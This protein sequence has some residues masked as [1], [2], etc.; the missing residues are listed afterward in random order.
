MRNKKDNTAT[1]RFLA[2]KAGFP[3]AAQIR[4]QAEQKARAIKPPALDSMTRKEILHMVY[5][6]QVKQIEADLQVKELRSEL[7][8]RDDQAGLFRIIS[9]NMLDMIALTDMEG[10][11]TF[12]G[13]SHE[14]LGYEP[15]FLIGKNVM[16]FV[17]P[18]DLPRVLE[19]SGVFFATGHPRRV[20]YRYKRADG[21]YLWLE[22]VGNFLRDECDTPQK[23]I[24]SSRDI[25][26]RKHAEQQLKESEERFSKAFRSSPAPQVIS[27]IDA[28]VFIDVNDRWM[29][30]LGYT[31]EQL[32]GQSSNEVG[33]WAAPGERDPIVQKLKKHGFFKNEPVEF[34]T[35]TGGTVYALWSAE[36]VTLGSRHVML[37]MIYDRTEHKQMEDALRESEQRLSLAMDAVSDGVW[38]WQTGTDH[39]YFSPRWY[40]M[41][42][43]KPYELPESFETWRRLLHPE[44]LPL[45]VELVKRHL[46]SAHPFETEFRMKTK[47]GDFK[48]IFARGKTVEKNEQGNPRRM[49]GTHMD[50]TG[51]KQAEQ[52][53]R[54]SEEKYRRIAENITDVVWTTDLNLNPT[55]VSSSVQKLLD[56][57][58]EEHM[59]R[60]MAEKL[61]PFY[62]NKIYQLLA[63][64]L[65]KENDP[66]SDKDRSRL[67]ELKHYKADGSTIWVSMNISAIRDEYGNF[68][69]LQ[70]VTRDI[71]EQKKREEEQEKLQ[72]QLYQAQKMES[73][74]RLAGGV[75][76]DFNNKLFI[77][78]GY[79]EMAIDMIE[80][81]GA[82]YENIR[83][84]HAAGQQSAGIVRQ[85]LAFARQQTISPVLL[86]L[87]DTISGMIK[88]LHRLLGENIDL[89]WLPGNNLWPV[90]IDPSQVDQ[91]M[92]NLAVNA[93]DAISDVGNLTIETKNKIID[94]DYC[95]SNP[96][97]VT[98][99]Y[100]M[101]AVSDDG[102]GMEKE[103]QNL[104]FE[105]FFTTKEIGKGTG[106]GLPTIYG[107]V[108]QNEGF[109]NVY[110]E[111][112]EGTTFSIY[113]PSQE[114]GKLS[115]GAAEK[116][117]AE[118]PKGSET[119]LLVEDEP[120]IL[121][122]GK[123]MI[124]RLGYK[125][126][127]A[128]RPEA[129][130]QLAAG[131]KE[132]IDLLI[133]DVVMP[134]MNGRDLALR[135]AGSQPGLK[136]LYMSGYTA[137][138][139]ARHGV[140]DKGVQFIQ[141]P[142]SVKDLA[143]KIRVAIAHG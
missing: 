27:D 138:V 18:E 16:D 28:G 113:L 45:A 130:V 132:K 1:T 13:K 46:T 106:L 108:K 136:I 117:A 67:I 77:I 80:P 19:E 61:P 20:E 47:N 103:V 143:V 70:G 35:S 114:A 127:S 137:D 128:E 66:A 5:N 23:I 36:A 25:T 141:K 6:M 21:T 30:M 12:A 116:S 59:R 98:G 81:N 115:S 60:T 41:L 100:V 49:L 38:D 82:L 96:E 14:I 26:D 71:S 134:E 72:N 11:F 86:D 126:L 73:V 140:L 124:R 84:I 62:L 63:E 119:I 112:G 78:N 74:G 133:T 109:I 89:A 142:L 7:E 69:G 2:N 90:K 10:N 107:I 88:M 8:E 53:L 104:L 110:S 57:T 105:P 39:V 40:T 48:W 87:N 50:I 17:H 99:K 42:G 76:H 44:D 24:Y 22:T 139:I 123:K 37:S 34:K 111:P 102:C 131:Y 31:R 101:L 93:R 94:E 91:I 97:A 85:L 125:V 92:A 52:K 33:I 32:L 122:M 79:A 43:Y 121:E 3:D 135:V 56:E 75:A 9:E 58:P 15:G 65:E 120:A 118:I 68:V 64:E 54:E 51:R 4:D 29:E 95:N 83:E 129:A 55:F